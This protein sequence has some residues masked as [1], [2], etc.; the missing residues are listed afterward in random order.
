MV[1][2][3]TTGPAGAAVATM[4][5]GATGTRPGMTGV[6]S[7]AATGAGELMLGGAFASAEAL[8]SFTGHATEQTCPL[9]PVERPRAGR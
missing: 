5:G 9:R 4:V 6:T 1:V 8:P 2:T 3:V 7:G